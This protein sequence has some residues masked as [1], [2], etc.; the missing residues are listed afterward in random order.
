MGMIEFPAV[1]GRDGR[2]CSNWPQDVKVRIVAG[3]RVDGATV[4]A[5]VRRYL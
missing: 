2:R 3:A 5:I 1:A 4:N